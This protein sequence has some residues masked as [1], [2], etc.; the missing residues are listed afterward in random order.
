MKPTPIVR[1]RKPSTLA[2][3]VF[4]RLVLLDNQEADELRN[5]PE[6]IRERFDDKRQKLLSKCAPDVRALAEQWHE[7]K[8]SAEAKAAE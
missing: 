6:S 7:A 4:D 8:K 3:G 5:A 2:A 1:V